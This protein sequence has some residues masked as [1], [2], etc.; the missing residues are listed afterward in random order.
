MISS[1]VI[2]RTC[3]V[4]LCSASLL[5]CCKK[6]A[7]LPPRPSAVVQVTPIPAVCNLPPGPSGTLSPTFLDDTRVLAPGHYIRYLPGSG[8][9]DYNPDT[10]AFDV[11]R[12]GTV[13]MEGDAFLFRRGVVEDLTLWVA[14]TITYRRAVE[15]CMRSLREVPERLTPAAPSG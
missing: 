8:Q 9:P 7:P 6:P 14:E 12:V 13:E 3:L 15:A 1:S 11:A 4:L 10:Q 2:S 5:A